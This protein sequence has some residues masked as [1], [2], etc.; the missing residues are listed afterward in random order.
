VLLW[1]ALDPARL[2]SDCREAIEDG[3]NDVFVSTVSAWEIA[4][5]QSLGK[6]ELAQPAERW[7]PRVIT[8]SGIDILPVDMA[9]ALRVRA[10]PWHHR[11]PFDRLLAAHALTEGLTLATRDAVFSAYGV[12]VLPA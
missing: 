6:L 7:L 3:E 1:A 4:V 12:A 9:A 10:L 2:S 5:K 8:R 11:D